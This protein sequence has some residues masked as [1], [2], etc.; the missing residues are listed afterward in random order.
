MSWTDELWKDSDGSG[1]AM[2]RR[3]ANLEKGIKESKERLM[4][5]KERVEK[6]EKRVK[7]N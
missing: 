2:R 6:L 4:K 3:I 7:S 5:L 1:D